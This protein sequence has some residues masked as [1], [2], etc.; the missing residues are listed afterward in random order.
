MSIQFDV[1]MMRIL[2]ETALAAFLLVLLMGPGVIPFLKRMKFGQEVRNDGPES[3]LKKQGTPTMGGIMI[4][5]AVILASAVGFA[6]S[7]SIPESALQVLFLTAAFG[8]IGFVD[9]YLKIRA[10]NSRGLSAGGKLALQL[11]AALLFSV[12]VWRRPEQ[13]ISA[14]TWYVPFTGFGEHAK[15]I[16][17]P[18]RAYLPLTVFV[19]L[20]T[21]NGVNFTDGLDG[22]CSSVTGVTAL[23]FAVTGLLMSEGV[24]L[25]S[26]AAAGALAGF[27]FFNSYPAKIFMGDTGSLALGGFV[28]ACAVIT[29]SELYL[30]IVGFV[31]MAEVLSVII[32]VGYFRITHGKRLFR[33]SPIHHHF[34]LCG[35]SETRIVTVFTILTAFLAG[36]SMIGFLY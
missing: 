32:Q 7:G 16:L 17:F 28:A 4:L 29:G 5:A 12:W 24:A 18:C 2:Y 30:L 6:A 21:D 25:V 20:G 15:R 23:F 26:A 11:A 27:L 22:L 14:G 10:H 1:P 34:E 36:L 8:T 19:I 35:N 13:G 3:H 33:M 31:Y 9:D